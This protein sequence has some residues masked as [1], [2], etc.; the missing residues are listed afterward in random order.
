MK[1]I[2]SGVAIIAEPK[3]TSQKGEP[4]SAWMYDGYTKV[5]VGTGRY[6]KMVENHIYKCLH[7]GWSV[8]VE[9]TKKPPMYCPNCGADM[10]G[11][12]HETN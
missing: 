7:C 8:R 11:E 10:R 12:Q 2:K 4:M 3:R 6:A 9:R 5:K 1:T